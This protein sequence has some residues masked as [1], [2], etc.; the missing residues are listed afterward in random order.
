[1][2][3]IHQIDVVEW[4]GKPN[5]IYING[6]RIV[7]DKPRFGER[8]HVTWFISEENLNKALNALNKAE[9]NVIPMTGKYFDKS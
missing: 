4:Q 7:G 6:V 9:S 2:K 3:K 8:I 5:A 1:M